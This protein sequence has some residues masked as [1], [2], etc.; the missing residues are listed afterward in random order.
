MKKTIVLFAV[1]MLLCLAAC[2]RANTPEPAAPSPIGE[3]QLANPWREISAAEAETLCPGSF[4]A[5]DGAENAVWSVLDS[6]ADPSGV[7]GP[8][9]QLAFDLNGNRFTARLQ[10]TDDKEADLSGMYYTWTVQDEGTLDIGTDEPL[11]CRFCR[12]IGENEYADLC[13][14][15]DAHSGVSYSLGVSARDLDGFDILAVAEALFR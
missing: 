2:G 11:P 6:V 3:T 13:A 15:Y 4:H 14:W 9:V 5:P 7:P 12:F 1:F 8:L 10:R